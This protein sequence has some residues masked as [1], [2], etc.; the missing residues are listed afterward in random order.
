MV[1][2]VKTMN[3]ERGCGLQCGLYAVK[4][5]FAPDGMKLFVFGIMILLTAP[6]MIAAYCGEHHDDPS[7]VI[8]YLGSMVDRFSLVV[9]F[10]ALLLWPCLILIAG[11]EDYQAAPWWFYLSQFVYL[12]GIACFLSWGI[13]IYRRHGTV[14]KA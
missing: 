13:R 3:N 6:L 11:L 10:G 7:P 4:N 2:Q 9:R 12:Y 1:R 8:N 14:E 5:F